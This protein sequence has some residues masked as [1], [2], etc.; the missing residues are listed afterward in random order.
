MSLFSKCRNPHIGAMSV[1]IHQE[2]VLG[3]LQDYGLTLFAGIQIHF[4][5]IHKLRCL[6]FL[7][8]LI[9]NI[10]SALIYRVISMM[11]W[12]KICKWPRSLPGLE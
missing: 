5:P 4:Y 2:S 12:I 7:G 6:S 3:S 9:S 11:N 10:V 8:C 1:R